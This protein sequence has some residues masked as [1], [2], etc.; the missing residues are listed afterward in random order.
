M[1][2]WI[3]LDSSIVFRF[4]TNTFEPRVGSGRCKEESGAEEC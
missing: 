4:V 3:L 2:G 1:L